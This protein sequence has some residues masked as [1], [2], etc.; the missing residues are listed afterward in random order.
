M[1]RHVTKEGRRERR[2]ER[3]HIVGRRGRLHRPPPSIR[4]LCSGGSGEGCSR[5]FC[6]ARRRSPAAATVPTTT[7]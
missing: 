6:P 5:G 4:V 3:P 2:G 1:G 7:A